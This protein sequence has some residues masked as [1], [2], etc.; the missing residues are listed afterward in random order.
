M[1]Y[2]SDLLYSK[3]SP[4]IFVAMIISSIINFVVIFEYR[5]IVDGYFPIML[6]QGFLIN[7]FTD[8]IYANCTTDVGKN[9]EIQYN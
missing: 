6:L 3:R 4:V 2:I 5:N 7:G 9:L 1:G 8:I